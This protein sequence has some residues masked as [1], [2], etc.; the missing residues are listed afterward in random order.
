MHTRLK[1]ARREA[2]LTQ[3]EVA[4]ITGI[5]QSVISAYESGAR[6]PGELACRT[7]LEALRV[8]PR[9]L[10]DR[11][12]SEVNDLLHRRGVKDLKVIGSVARG[13]DDEGSDIDLLAEFPPGTTLLDLM[14]LEQEIEAIVGTDVD[15]ISIRGL[16]PERPEQRAILEEAIPL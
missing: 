1:R 16:D 14:E 10:L 11:H 12:R 3:A 5:K 2:G 7:I 9:D 8:K 13:E 6:M 15:L 4:R